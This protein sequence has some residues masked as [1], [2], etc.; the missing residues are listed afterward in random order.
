MIDINDLDKRI[1]VLE[2]ELENME[3]SIMKMDNIIQD[4][5][6]GTLAIKERLDK[7]NR[8]HSSYGRRRQEHT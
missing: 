6:E 4:N 5:Y 1:S 2:V 3:K 8:Q 7:W